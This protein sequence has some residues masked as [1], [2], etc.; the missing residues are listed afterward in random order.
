MTAMLFNFEFRT[1]TRVNFLRLTL[2]LTMSWRSLRSS[3]TGRSRKMLRAMAAR[4][5]WM[6]CTRLDR[7]TALLTCKLKH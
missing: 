6:R 3:E 1:L 5:S 4:S 2:L 7:S